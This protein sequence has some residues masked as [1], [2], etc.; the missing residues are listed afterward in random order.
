MKE[1]SLLKFITNISTNIIIQIT[2]MLILF[3]HVSNAFNWKCLGYPDRKLTIENR[4]KDD[5]AEY[6]MKKDVMTVIC[7]SDLSTVELKLDPIA[8]TTYCGGFFERAYYC[9]AFI[10]EPYNWSR[11][12]RATYDTKC[13]ECVRESEC[14]WQIRRDNPYVYESSRNAF[15]P[16]KY[17]DTWETRLC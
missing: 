2:L 4:F 8:T 5:Y 11:V 10:K 15:V 16:K 7:Y 1:T 13:L 14:K 17:R 3:C 6:D 9:V 12:W